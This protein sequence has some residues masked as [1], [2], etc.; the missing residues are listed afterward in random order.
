MKFLVQVFFTN[1]T[2]HNY[3]VEADEI[4]QI[5][6]LLLVYQ[7]NMQSFIFAGTKSQP[8]IFNAEHVLLIVASETK[9]LQEEVPTLCCEGEKCH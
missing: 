8:C 1:N 2:Q 7:E 3:F 5:E 6:D 4:E 9:E